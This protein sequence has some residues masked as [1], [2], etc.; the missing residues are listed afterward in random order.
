M[1]EE[2]AVDEYKLLY[3]LLCYGVF[4]SPPLGKHTIDGNKELTEDLGI[5]VT[6][7]TGSANSK[8]Q[9]ATA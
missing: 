2:T 8:N 4:A 7:M 5:M 1:S 9:A 3:K 6:F